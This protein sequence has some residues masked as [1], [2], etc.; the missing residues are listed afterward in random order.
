MPMPVRN[1]SDTFAGKQ[2]APPMQSWR[3]MLLDLLLIGKRVI[4]SF[5]NFGPYRARLRILFTGQT[6]VPD[7]LPY[8]WYN[9][10]YQGDHIRDFKRF[11]R[12]IGVRM[13]RE[14]SNLWDYHV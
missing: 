5:P 2:S 1:L 12:T 4:V 3:R 13:V 14:T 10:Q 8:E 7:Q 9:S 11:L 6:P